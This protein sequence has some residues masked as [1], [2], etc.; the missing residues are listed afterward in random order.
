MTKHKTSDLLLNDLWEEKK[1][2]EEEEEK[3]Q[4]WFG[5]DEEAFLLVLQGL[6][7]YFVSL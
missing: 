5:M 7:L 6:H 3:I 4:P 1:K 2:V